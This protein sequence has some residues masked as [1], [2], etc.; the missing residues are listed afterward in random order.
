MQAPNEEVENLQN[1][2]NEAT[3][4]DRQE[5]AEMQAQ[6]KEDDRDL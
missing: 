6:Q 4:E 5:A 2:Y 1:M 3:A